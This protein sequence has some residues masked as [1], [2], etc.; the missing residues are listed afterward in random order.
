MY[1]KQQHQQSPKD[2][3]WSHSGMVRGNQQHRRLLVIRSLVQRLISR[4]LFYAIYIFIFMFD[5]TVATSEMAAREPR[6]L[7]FSTC[8]VCSLS[9]SCTLQP[10]FITS[11]SLHINYLPSEMA[12]FGNLQILL[13]ILVATQAHAWN[14]RFG[15]LQ[16]TIKV[17]NEPLGPPIGPDSVPFS[18]GQYWM[19]E[20]YFM[21]K[22]R[23]LNSLFLPGTHGAGAWNLVDPDSCKRTCPACTER[24]LV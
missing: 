19:S 22:N 8:R 3:A 16:R 5:K 10:N 18:D 4:I 13:L 2:E 17:G 24:L 21:M 9:L 23:P 1:G 20:I 6:P 15:F 7:F 11:S 14:W 12:Q